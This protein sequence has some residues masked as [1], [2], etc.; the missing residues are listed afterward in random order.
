[1]RNKHVNASSDHGDFFDSDE[2]LGE[3][4][5]SAVRARVDAP[6]ANPPVSLITKRAQAQARAKAVQRTVVGIAASISL[7]AGGIFAFNALDNRGS[8][9]TTDDFAA[10]GNDNL[11]P[12]NVNESLTNNP[13]SVATVTWEEVQE[14]DLFAG[15]PNSGDVDLIVGKP[16]TVGDGR[17]FVVTTSDSG[18][19]INVLDNGGEW[20][21]IAVPSEVSAEIVDI[22]GD[23][24]L[25]AGPDTTSMVGLP[26]AYYSDNAGTDWTEVGFGDAAR[27]NLAYAHLN[28][29]LTSGEN[30]VFVYQVAGSN[31]DM[32]MGTQIEAL[33]SESGLLP[34]GATIGMTEYVGSTISFATADDPD[35]VLSFEISEEQLAEL[36]ASRVGPQIMVYASN[37]DT[38]VKTGQYN[39]SHTTGYSNASGFYVAITTDTNELLLTSVDGVAWAETSIDKALDPTEIDLY[40]TYRTS[41]WFVSQR[42]TIMGLRLEVQSLGEV[43]DKTA[44]TAT[45]ADTSYLQS[46]D[47]GPSVMVAVANPADELL[48]D[49]SQ[50]DQLL[51]WSTNG[52]DWQWQTLTEVFGVDQVNYRAFVDL[53]VGSDYVI[54]RVEEFPATNETQ[55]LDVQTRVTWFKAT[56]S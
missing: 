30:M 49:P 23:R 45:L 13:S 31:F 11:N 48:A 19:H 36:E 25:V 51:G 44:I 52:S 56:L 4:L 54:A 26:R 3:A 37:G 8:I 53:G 47:I 14:Q 40:G 32:D 5:G 10:P 28:L 27:E 1:M 15:V 7:V 29:A 18:Q 21:Q 22:S 17:V 50:A 20:T 39:S 24:W 41:G 55:S 46:L 16:T 43:A 2:A 33:I 34:S 12:T 42:S 38:A 6:V 35:T 9:T